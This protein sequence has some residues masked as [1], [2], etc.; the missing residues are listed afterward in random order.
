MTCTSGLDTR[1]EHHS[2]WCDV[3]NCEKDAEVF[4]FT[5][6]AISSWHGLGWYRSSQLYLEL[7]F[8]FTQH[9][10]SSKQGCNQS[11]Y[12]GIINSMAFPSLMLILGQ[13]KKMQCVPSFLVQKNATQCSKIS[14]PRSSYYRPDLTFCQ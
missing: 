8:V 3:G 14:P 10:Y 9:V 2:L 4:L 6:L 11:K 12:I 1:N 13:V 7:P 5:W